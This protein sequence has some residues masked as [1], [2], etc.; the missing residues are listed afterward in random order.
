MNIVDVTAENAQQ[1]VIDAS[2]EKL[3]I[4]D[5]W[6]DWCAPCKVL[7]PILEKLAAEYPQDLV[8]AKINADEQQ[9]L[10]AQFGVRSL[11]TVMLVKEG[12]PLDG[13]TGAKTE[14]EIRELL[15]KYLPKAWEAEV[16]QAQLFI[17]A[18]DYQQALPLLRRAYEESGKLPA[19]A[20][21][22]G[23][24]YAQL[25]RLDEAQTLLGEIKM[26]D[27]DAVYEQALAA[28]ELKR[29]TAKTPELAKLEADYEQRP[30]DLQLAYE[31]ALQL[32]E[33]HQH[34]AALE[35]LLMIVTRDR[36]FSEGAA[37]K[38]ITDIIA[39]LGKGDP[40]AVEFQ[41]KLF[42]LLY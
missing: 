2:F 29:Q 42:T 22:L 39:T 24:V 28:L 13:F 3:V 36:N 10:A 21:L 26:A 23:L 25:N 11:P 40:L 27:Q 1:M 7:M 38:S 9:M 12:Q 16:Q 14:P 17:Q 4:V 18:G 37:R 30:D 15:E 20:A 8:L 32:N 34:R 35:L 31:L 19:L 41:R 33:E 6:A 5:F